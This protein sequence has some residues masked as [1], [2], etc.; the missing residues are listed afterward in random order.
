MLYY[1]NYLNIRS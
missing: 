1:V